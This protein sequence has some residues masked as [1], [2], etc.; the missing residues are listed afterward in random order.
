VPHNAAVSPRDVDRVT[1]DATIFAKAGF[2]YWSSL[3]LAAVNSSSVSSPCSRNCPGRP[4][5][6][7]IEVLSGWGGGQGGLHVLC[8]Y[9]YVE[10]HLAIRVPDGG[11]YPSGPHVLDHDE[12]GGRAWV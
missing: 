7:I 5:R 9:P 1:P 3:A 11:R 12:E 4:T 2:R 10:Q 6:L 8:R